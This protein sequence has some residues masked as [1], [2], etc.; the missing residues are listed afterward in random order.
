MQLEELSALL[1]QAQQ[2]KSEPGGTY[3]LF[4]SQ[5]TLPPS[6]SLITAGAS[7]GEGPDPAVHS[8]GPG[9]T[10][11]RA[12]WPQAPALPGGAAEQGASRV[13]SEPR[14]GTAV[15]SCHVLPMVRAGRQQSKSCSCPSWRGS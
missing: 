10:G 6:Y 12:G 15:S 9:R 1:Q 2:D 3:P 4:H 5:L 7:T 11:A 14:G 8:G 13:R